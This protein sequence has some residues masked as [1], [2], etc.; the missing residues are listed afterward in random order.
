MEETIISNNYLMKLIDLRKLLFAFR[1]IHYGDIIPDLKLNI[2]HRTEEL[3]K[4]LLRLY[5]SLDDAPIALN[6]IRLALS[7]FV[8]ERNKLKKNSL[9]SK[10]YDAVNNLISNGKKILI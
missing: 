1:M 9:E 10:L 3:S 5:S 7:V 4:P 2:R 6:E 8:A